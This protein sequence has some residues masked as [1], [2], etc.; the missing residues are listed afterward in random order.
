MVPTSDTDVRHALQCYAD[1]VI[2]LQTVSQARWP[3]GPV[4]PRCQSRDLSFLKT[5]LLWTCLDCRKQFSVK[6]GTIFEVS[7]IGLDKWLAA[8]WMVA[9]YGSQISSYEVARKL[10]VTQRTAWFMLHRIRYALRT[11][12]QNAAG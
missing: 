7:A 10:S 4:C 12:P 1:P 9:H 11:V 2:C 3:D 8:L 5:R 6:V